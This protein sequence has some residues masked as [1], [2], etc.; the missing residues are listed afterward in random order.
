MW[1]CN[2]IRSLLTW[3]MSQSYLLFTPFFQALCSGCKGN[4]LAW[5]TVHGDSVP[6]L[7][8]RVWEQHF[9]K[10]RAAI[11]NASQVLRPGLPEVSPGRTQLW[12][13]G[14]L[15]SREGGPHLGYRPI[16]LHPDAHVSIA[17]AGSPGW[18]RG[19]L[20][21]V[22]SAQGL[23]GWWGVCSPKAVEEVH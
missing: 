7:P 19:V 11:P 12:S 16:H 1:L 2:D 22:P 15:W 5:L 14:L 13:L 10:A 21:G 23:P 4:V 17:Q 18:W 8:H 9:W 3:I 6:P 20:G